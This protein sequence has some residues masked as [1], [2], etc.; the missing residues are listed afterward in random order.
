MTPPAV[1][2]TV[3]AMIAAAT[4]TSIELKAIERPMPTA[5]PAFP[6]TPAA[7]D[8]PT[9]TLRIEEKSSAVMVIDDARTVLGAMRSPP[10]MA[11]RVEAWMRF[12][13]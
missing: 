12:S 6:L 10:S 7:R 4:S 13:A 3:A 2:F 11:A 1:V 8:A 5:T 9:A